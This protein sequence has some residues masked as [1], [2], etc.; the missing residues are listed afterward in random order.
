MSESIVLTGEGITY[1][2]LAI[3]KGALKLESKG[4]KTRG[5]ALR[6]KLASKLGL[7]AKDSYETYITTIQDKMT[8]ILR[9][10]S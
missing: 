3:W 2:Q 10:K 7:K 9:N 4:L 6:P 5:G 8:V 1:A